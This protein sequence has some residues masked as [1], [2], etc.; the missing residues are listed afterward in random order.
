[1]NT[2]VFLGLGSNLG[3]R[4]FYIEKALA[5]LNDAGLEIDKCSSLY[6][7]APWGNPR[8]RP[9]LNTVCRLNCP[10]SPEELLFLCQ[11]TEKFLG[12]KTTKGGYQNRIIDIDILFFG[13]RI[14]Q[15]DKLKIPHPEIPSRKFVLVGMNEIA[16]DF[17]DPALNQTMADLFQST[18][19]PLAVELWGRLDSF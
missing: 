3:N 1:M 14:L 10:F 7:S 8:L 9:F 13:N 17:V 16:A 12:R 19:D 18:N 4:Q 11:K 2:A 5:E 15:T 6:W